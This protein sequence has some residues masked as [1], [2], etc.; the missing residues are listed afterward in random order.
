MN[1]LR[2]IQ[3]FA[4]YEFKYIITN[5]ISNQIESEVKNFMQYDGYASK[6]KNNSYYVRSQYYDNDLST[7]FYEKVDG[8]KDR[9]KYRIRTY[10]PN[11]RND[12]P[13]FLEKKERKLERTFK[14][15]YQI[16]YDNLQYFYKHYFDFRF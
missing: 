1:N 5:D 3:E 4:R 7:H 9:Y 2:K 12:N 16:D 6:E 8:M 13:I 15:R 10:G 11:H 14:Q